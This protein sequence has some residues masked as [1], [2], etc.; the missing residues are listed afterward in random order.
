MGIKIAI[1]ASRNRSGGA[2]AH[3]IGIIN[4]GNPRQHGIDEVHIWSY[5]SLLDAL[6]DYPWLVKHN[7]PQLEMG[8]LKQLW[9][10]Y[11][12]FPKEVQQAGCDILLSTDAGTVCIYHPSIVM[13]RD[14]LSYERREIARY[15]M[16][17]EWLRLF[18]LRFVQSRSLKNADACIF[19]TRYAADVIQTWT[20]K[21]KE[22]KV[23]PHGVSNN[24]RITD[25]NKKP[26]AD[27]APVQCLYVSN[28]ALYKHQWCVVEAFSILNKK[29]YNAHITFAGGGAG[30][31]QDKFTAAIAQYD[32][33]E[34]F[35]TRINK[36]SH[37]MV[38]ELL[39][40]A[41]IFIFASSCENMPN[42]L[43]E[44]MASG[45]PIA[46]SNLGPMPEVLKDGGVYF[47]PENAVSIADATEKI[48]T[49]SHLKTELARRAKE[50]SEQYSWKRCATETFSYLVE[51]YQKNQ[52]KK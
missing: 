49:D 6:P 36:V 17:K 21:I 8:M 43:V 9:W 40:K 26:V 2:K 27:N 20:G 45:L 11:K 5:K 18:I 22:Y 38:P 50:L 39:S 41:D 46:C 32:P 30:P 3:L 23:V 13:S 47:D 24:F 52:Q 28:A 19:L 15:G 12:N 29:G 14:M 31:G 10:Q 7:P 33:Q 34:T 42:T 51:V 1:D 44:A 37:D 48:L 16:G 25:N 4:D 35:T